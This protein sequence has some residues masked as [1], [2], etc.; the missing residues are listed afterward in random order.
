[1]ERLQDIR[2]EVKGKLRDARAREN[3]W[4]TAMDAHIFDLVK[5]GQLDQAEDE[6]RNAIDSNRVKP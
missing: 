3:F 1:M 2:Q 4:R 5:A 6:L